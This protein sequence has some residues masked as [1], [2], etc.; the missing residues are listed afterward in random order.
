VGAAAS[1]VFRWRVAYVADLV[2]L[3][4]ETAG[5]VDRILKGAKAAELAIEQPNQVRAGHHTSRPSRRARPDGPAVA[6]RR[7][8]HVIE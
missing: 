4:R 3:Y 7:A 1:S 8:D 6:V 5:Y 2:D